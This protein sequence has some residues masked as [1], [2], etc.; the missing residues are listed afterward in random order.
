MDQAKS[1]PEELIAGYA[2][3]TAPKA[4]LNERL[5]TVWNEVRHDPA[6]VADAARALG[7]TPDELRSLEQPPFAIGARQQGIGV[8]ET[9][10]IVFVADVAYDLTKDIA[11]DAARAALKRLWDFTKVRI[12]SGLPL[13]AFGREVRPDE[14]QN[15]DGP[16]TAS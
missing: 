15:R 13:G 5:A 14:V 9:A 6:L 10:I 11:K 8:V 1:G 7:V 2:T 12:E 4:E 16:P 3:G